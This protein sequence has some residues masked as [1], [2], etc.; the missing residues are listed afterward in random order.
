MRATLAEL[1]AAERRR[2]TQKAADLGE[3]CP[4]GF[5]RLTCACLSEERLPSKSHHNCAVAGTTVVLTLSDRSV[6]P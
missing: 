5:V 1:R 6:K 4:I 2:A 3:T